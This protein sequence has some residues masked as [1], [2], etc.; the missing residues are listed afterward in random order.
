MRGPTLRATATT[1]QTIGC[2]LLAA[3]VIANPGCRAFML[4]WLM[5]GKPPTKDV[6]APYPYLPGKEVCLVVRA[7]M[8]TLVEYPHVQYELADHVQMA[9]EAHVE[10]LEVVDPKQVVDFQRKRADW[11]T[12]DP[13]ALGKNFKADRLIELQLTRYTTRDPESPYQKRGYISAVM[14]VYNTDYPNSG[15]AYT[16]EVQ[17]L[18]PPDGPSPWGTDERELRRATMEVFAEEVANHFYDRKVEVQ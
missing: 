14:N 17:A 1:K 4:P 2:V 12:M 18:H 7:E 8:E 15:P 5:W 3:L 16:A 11:E 10:N 13:A 9:L 6:P